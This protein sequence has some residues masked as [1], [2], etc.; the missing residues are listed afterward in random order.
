MIFK[1]IAEYEDTDSE[2]AKFTISQMHCKIQ[3]LESQNKELARLNIEKVD[4]ILKAIEYIKDYCILSD[5]WEE[6]GFCNFAPIG[7]IKYTPLST[8]KVKELLEILKGG[9]EDNERNIYY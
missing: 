9:G 1:N 2:L 5:V 6:K 4:I 8:K 3:E 7:K